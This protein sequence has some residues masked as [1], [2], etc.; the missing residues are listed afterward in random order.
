M[1]SYIRALQALT[2]PTN[3]YYQPPARSLEQDTAKRD[4]K[5]GL[6]FLTRAAALYSS[7]DSAASATGYSSGLTF[8]RA[9]KRYGI[10]PPSVRRRRLGK[11]GTGMP[12]GAE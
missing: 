7:N 4:R 11:L 9:C 8:A 1:H 2:A 10:D 5:D 6:A 12:P 3:S